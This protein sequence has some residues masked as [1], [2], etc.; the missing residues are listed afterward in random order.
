MRS[1]NLVGVEGFEPSKWRS[2]SPL[3][4]RL[5]TPQ[6]MYWTIQL[7]YYITLQCK[8]QDENIYFFILTLMRSCAGIVWSGSAGAA[9]FFYGYKRPGSPGVKGFLLFYKGW[10]LKK[11]YIIKNWNYRTS[12]GHPVAFAQLRSPL[13]S[14]LYHKCAKKSNIYFLSQ[15]YR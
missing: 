11:S 7:Y 15:V 2:Q 8:S 14:L 5:A 13:L 6:Y 3:P 4:Y 12:K 10:K 9:L 1:F